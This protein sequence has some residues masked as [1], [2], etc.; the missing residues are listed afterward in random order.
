MSFLAIIL[1][2]CFIILA[3]IHFNWANGGAWGLE[4]AIPTNN[5]GERVL[6][7]SKFDSFT[8]GLIL[9]FFAIFYLYLFN[10]TKFPIPAWV[11][12]IGVWS[13][14][15]IFLLRAIGD[16]KYVGLFKKVKHTTFG[17]TDT[18]IFIPLCLA[19]SIIGYVI[20]LP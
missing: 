1:S 17:K 8:V 11:I 3:I 14:P 15:S 5:D 9:T 6:N 13:I 10:F 7:P 12:K 2:L 20:A 19:I 4:K 16:F 18:L